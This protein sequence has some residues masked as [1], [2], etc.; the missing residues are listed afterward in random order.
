MLW[1][2]Y[3]WFYV[4]VKRSPP[5]DALSKKHPNL[6]DSEKMKELGFIKETI[7]WGNPNAYVV[8]GN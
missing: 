1:L 7:I 5:C 4:E 8:K 6:G 3:T 2:Y